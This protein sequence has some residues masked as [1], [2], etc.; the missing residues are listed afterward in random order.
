M[1]VARLQWIER[2]LNDG[3]IPGQSI[4][5]L[6]KLKHTSDAQVL[7]PGE[8]PYP[9]RVQTPEGEGREGEREANEA[10]LMESTQDLP[11]KI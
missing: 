4:F 8:N 11:G 5:A 7:I 6:R 10:L 2:P 9:V 3:N 1:G